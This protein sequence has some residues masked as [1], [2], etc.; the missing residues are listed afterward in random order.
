GYSE[1]TIHENNW[2]Y[3]RIVSR[4]FFYPQ[5]SGS[6]SQ[7]YLGLNLPIAENLVIIGQSP[8]IQP[9]HFLW[10]ID[11]KIINANTLGTINQNIG[12]DGSQNNKPPLKTIE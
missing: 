11:D 8:K 10:P 7:T 4:N 9:H 6:E 5:Y 12:Y 1:S 3:D 2:Y